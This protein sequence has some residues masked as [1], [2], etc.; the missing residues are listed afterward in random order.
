MTFYCDFIRFR[1]I[2]RAAFGGIKG[3]PRFL[4][5]FGTQGALQF[6][7]GLVRAREIGMA[8]KKTF[9]VVIRV[10]KWAARL[11]ARYRGLGCNCPSR[12]KG[13]ADQ[14]ERTT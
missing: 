4:V 6:F 12:R 5:D 10:W 8:N 14:P 3:G 11:C 7:V 9:A 13:L 1:R 2:K